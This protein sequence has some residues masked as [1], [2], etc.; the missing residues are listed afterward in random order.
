M[1]IKKNGH[2]HKDIIL[3]ILEIPLP[4][5]YITFW[6]VALKPKGT[7]FAYYFN[8]CSIIETKIADF[9][10]LETGRIK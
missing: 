4:C 1:W 9:I 5:Q 7:N 8:T 6:R 10:N 3:K 2:A